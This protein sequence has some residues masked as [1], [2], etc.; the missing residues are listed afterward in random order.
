MVFCYQSILL[1]YAHYTSFMKCLMS[2]KK[3]AC[4]FL[5]GKETAA[6]H[7]VSV[8]GIACVGLCNVW[9]L[10]APL[11][12]ERW[13]V[14]PVSTK[15]QNSCVSRLL[16]FL[17][18]IAVPVGRYISPGSVHARVITPP[19]SLGE[20]EQTAFVWVASDTKVFVCGLSC[21]DVERQPSGGAV[22]MIWIKD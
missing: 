4:D 6:A 5:C 10:R 14:M 2:H 3:C 13:S 19:R 8:E 17:V 9:I 20:S 16:L 7:L 12:R 21:G 1:Q 18:Y 15:P 22:F 11:T